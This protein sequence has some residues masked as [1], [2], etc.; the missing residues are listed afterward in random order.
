MAVYQFIKTQREEN[1]YTQEYIAGYLGCTRQ[2]YR[3]IEAGKRELTLSELEKLSALFESS[4]NDLLA[5][6][7]SAKHQVVVEEEKAEPNQSVKNAPVQR[8]RISVPQN[9]VEKFKEVLL[10]ILEKRGAE[11][12][13]GQTVIY[14]LL[15]F[16]DFDYYEKYEDQLI[17]ARYIKNYFGPMPVEFEK[18][19]DQMI[20]QGDLEKV[21]SNFFTYEQTKYLPH[22][23]ADLSLLTACEI[24]HIDLVLDRLGCK[25]TSELSHYSH[26]DVPWITAKEGEE[27][28]Y[29]T[30]FYRTSETT[31][32]DYESDIQ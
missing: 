7:E 18:I 29:E 9:R 15:Y 2:T 28:D 8:T 32:R 17:G 10:Y 25:N 23:S 27:L 12:H 5:E 30:V 26:Q 16:I 3:Q 1:K 31:V 19:T 22:R 13:V 20:Q 4:L 21:K 11:P 14:K 6:R 24:K